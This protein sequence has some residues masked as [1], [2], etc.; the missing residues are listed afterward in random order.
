MLVSQNE[1]FLQ[2]SRYI[3]RNLIETATPMVERLK[4]YPWSSYSAYVGL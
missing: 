4:G 2:L 3:H 1:C